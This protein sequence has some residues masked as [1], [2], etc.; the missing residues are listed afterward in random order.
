MPALDGLRGLAVLA[1]VLYHAGVAALGG[2]FLGVDLFFVLSGYLITALLLLEWRSTGRIR[3]GRFWER[4]VRRLLPALL[5]VLVTVFYL[6][7]WFGQAAATASRGDVG[8]TLAY[9]QNW[10]L[11]SGGRGYFEQSALPSPLQ[12][13]WSLSIEEQFYLVWPLVLSGVFALLRRRAGAVRGARRGIR[14]VLVGALVAAVASAVEMALLYRPGE[15]PSRVYYG[16]D[17]RATSLLLGAILALASGHG[18]HASDAE[19]RAGHGWTPLG[20]GGAATL[21]VLWVAADGSSPWLYRG[22][23]ALG[24]LAAVLVIAAVVAQPAGLLARLLSWLPLRGLG[25]ISYGIYLWHWPIFGLVTSTRTGLQGVALLMAR[26]IVTL[27]VAVISLRAIEIP[28]RTR[29]RP[30]ALRSSPA[31]P[32]IRPG[33][34]ARVLV[35]SFAGAVVVAQVVAMLVWSP[36]SVVAVPAAGAQASDADVCAESTGS[37]ALGEAAD[38]APPVGSPARPG[39]AQRVRTGSA[40]RLL[41]VGDSV[42]KSLA[43]GLGSYAQP[44]AVQVTDAAVLGCGITIGGPYRYSGQLRQQGHQ[45]LGWEAR[46]RAAL[47][48]TK[49]EAVALLVGRWE[50][51]DRSYQGRWTH[52]GD[53]VYD[54]YLKDQL[55]RALALLSATH[56]RVVIVTAPYYRRGEQ[57]NGELWPED[58]P[59]RAD[60]WNAMLR[61]VADSANVPVVDLDRKA[62]PAGHYQETVD[63]VRLRYDGVHLRKEAV[64]SLGPWLLPRLL[65]SAA[66]PEAV[67]PTPAR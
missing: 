44:G 28:L 48:R 6:G 37:S 30:A 16:T 57:P 46:W 39:A 41:I 33:G 59:E 52:I 5:V 15:D 34:P 12:H 66:R 3:L 26:L 63:G 21:A 47:N 2:G 19:S 42:A 62:G 1:V 58:V 22:G 38:S 65:G 11:L 43:S 36:T 20:W 31:A 35:P 18:R 49:P 17:T 10:H 14:L 32:V 25:T 51:M 53:P 67:K 27:A 56:G 50:V 40:R 8:A 60:R 7:R 45:C 4:R 9:V 54:S 13:T 23:T 61:Q 64:R 29:S 55:K 24:E